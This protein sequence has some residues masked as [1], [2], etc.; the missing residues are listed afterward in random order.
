MAAV[1][2][3]ERERSVTPLAMPVRRVRPSSRQLSG[4][5]EACLTLTWLTC[6]ECTEKLTRA[7]AGRHL[8]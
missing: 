5:T 2:M 6:G 8:G 4:L 7:A 3:P 1:L